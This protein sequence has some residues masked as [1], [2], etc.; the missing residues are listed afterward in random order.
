MD[1]GKHST[2]KISDTAAG[3][4]NQNCYT[5]AGMREAAFQE[6][7]DQEVCISEQWSLASMCLA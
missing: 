4:L 6:G 1:I 2:R 5:A 3:F 7:V